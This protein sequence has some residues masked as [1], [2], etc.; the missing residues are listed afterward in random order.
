MVGPGDVSIAVADTGTG[1][2]TSKVGHIFDGFFT[3]KPEGMRMGLSILPL[4]CRSAWWPAVGVAKFDSGEHLSVHCADG[5]RRVLND[6]TGC[7]E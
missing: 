6:S 4:D 2:D 5:G 3:T 1:L 7:L